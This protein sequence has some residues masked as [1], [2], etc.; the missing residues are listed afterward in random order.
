MPHP[1]HPVDTHVGGVL[2]DLRTARGLS[3]SDLAVRLGLSFQQVQKYERGAN[4]I[5]ASKLFELAQILGEDPAV[6]FAGL[7]R[8]RSVK[9]AAAPSL[10]A[11]RLAM[12]FDRIPKGPTG[13]AVFK[14]VEALAR[15][16]VR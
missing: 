5:S 12:L 6:F 11:A 13:D 3:Q 16:A 10:R 1:P 4:R 2:R 7:R 14:L 9:S 15:T 8:G